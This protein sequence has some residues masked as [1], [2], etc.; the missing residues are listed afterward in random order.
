M[1]NQNAGRQKIIQV[2]EKAV[3]EMKDEPAN[4]VRK[5]KIDEIEKVK[6]DKFRKRKQGAERKKEEN[7]ELEITNDKGF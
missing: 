6:L 2:V 3:L 5:A 7:K 1:R 4:V